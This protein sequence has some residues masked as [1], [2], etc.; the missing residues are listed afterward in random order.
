MGPGDVRDRPWLHRFGACQDWS[1]VESDKLAGQV[2]SSSGEQEEVE[3][4]DMLEDVD[5][6]P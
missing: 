5:A 3:A 2:I 4:G 1:G 6:N